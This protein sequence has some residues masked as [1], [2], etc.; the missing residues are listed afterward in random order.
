MKKN[1]GVP[2]P[3]EGET[4]IA[5]FHKHEVRRAFHDGE[6]FFSVTDVIAA[7]TESTRPAK[8]WADLKKKL[9]DEGGAELSDKIG[10]LKMAGPDGKM[11][12]VHAANTET[13]FRI[14]QSI[15]SPRA[16]PFKRWLA[17]VGFERL[18]ETRNPELAIRRAI[19]TYQL[20]GYPDDW[21]NARIKTIA[22][23]NELTGEWK[24]RGVTEGIEYAVLTNVISTETFD[25]PTQGHKEYKG[26]A[27][28]DNLR[29]HMT[30]IELILTMLGEKSTVSIAI[31]RDAQGFAENNNA[32]HAG[33]KIAGGARRKLEAELGRSVVSPENFLS[34]K[35]TQEQLVDGASKL[36]E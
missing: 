21:I 28:R 8:Y 9:L 14:I 24:K 15:P 31:A 17:R 1:L 19:V 5:L 12:S 34:N 35:E 33:G 7:V 10:Q 22:S 36:L 23:R 27:K 32:A 29:D 13:V 11:Y 6:W 2:L 25:M 3:F 18:Q 30:D 26:L 20:L 4:T 16:E